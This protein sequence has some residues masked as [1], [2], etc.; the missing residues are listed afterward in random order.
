MS[1]P[2]MLDSGWV[3]HS[4]L[5]SGKNLDKIDARNRFFS[6][7]SL[8]YV[9]TSPGANV[10][11]NPPPQFCRFADIKA[12]SIR[13]NGTNRAGSGLYGTFNYGTT[14]GRYY[15]EAL[16]DNAHLVHFRMGKTA[17]TS[18]LNYLTG[19]YSYHAS[20]VAR[21]G[22]A[23]GFFYALGRAS[24]M[25]VAIMNWRIVAS[26][27]VY[28]FIRF[29]MGRPK[30]KYAYLKPT[31]PVYWATVQT[32]VNHIATNMGIVTPVGSTDEA[33]YGKISDDGKV[34]DEDE[35]FY[36]FDAHT[37]AGLKSKL[38]DIFDEHGNVNVYAMATKGQ[39]LANYHK[40]A[41]RNALDSHGGSG[42]NEE[43]VSL[44][45]SSIRLPPNKYSFK[46]YLAKW[47]DANMFGFFQD[48]TNAMGVET[49]EDMKKEGDTM[50]DYMEAEMNDGAAFVTFRVEEG[51]AIS[52]SFSNSAQ[53]SDLKGKLDGMASAVRSKINMFSGG[54]FGDGVVSNAIETVASDA[55]QFLGGNLDQ[56]GLGG[57]AGITGGGYADIP[58]HWESSMSSMPKG[59]YTIKLNTP[60]NNKI[61]KLIHEIIPLCMILAMGLPHSTGPQSYTGPFMLEFYDRGRVQ[62]RYGM[63]D[64]ISVTRG[65]ASTP[66][67]QG[68]MWNGIEVNLSIVDLTSVMHMPLSE[69]FTHKGMVNGSLLGGFVSSVLGALGGTPASAPAAGA[70]GAAAGGAIGALSDATSALG[71]TVQQIFSDETLFSDY[72]S[73]L[74][75]LG[76]AD[77]IYS[78]R[79][80]RLRLTNAMSQWRTHYS[81]PAI[82]M[83]YGDSAPFELAKLF[84][85]GS[86]KS[87]F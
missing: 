82:A 70:E 31:M 51:G 46:E 66:F 20:Y 44:Y 79:R 15:S 72:M 24:G 21:T 75:G 86:E 43:I 39:R 65:T 60:Y 40:L 38:P 50:M 7:A 25:V 8:K 41:V 73:V 18:F 80:L 77:N 49:N 35:F 9:D 62:C 85:R 17:F 2:I 56:M 48:S 4:F 5:V 28:R 22:R 53:D 29:M 1:S 67:S 37:A 32:L 64:Q 84:F 26:I 45:R 3:R 61:S 34:P 55:A 71:D 52:E 13:A 87:F 30:T 10:M 57:L 12:P 54:N 14:L 6:S 33:T 68:R 69:G 74:S 16:D 59:N 11:I 42:Y 47:M 81:V 36:Q 63:V 23:P 27:L 78:G 58:Q 83:A 76:L 19:Y